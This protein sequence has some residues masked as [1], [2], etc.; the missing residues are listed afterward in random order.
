VFLA[1]TEGKITVLKAGAE[2]EVLAVNEINDD[3]NATPPRLMDGSKC[4]RTARCTASA[5]RGSPA[6]A[7]RQARGT[8]LVHFIALLRNLVGTGLGDCL[9]NRSS[10]WK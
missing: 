7:T 6:T 10:L 4:G 8:G 3:V 9:K 5:P 2:W 1:N